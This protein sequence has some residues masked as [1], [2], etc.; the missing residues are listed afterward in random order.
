MVA[1][2]LA[3]LRH[4][5]FRF[6]W[7]GQTVSAIGDQLNVVAIAAL[8][9]SEG[10]GAGA[11]GIVLAARIAGMVVF[12]PLAGVV[13]DRLPRRSVMAGADVVRGLSVLAI[14]FVALG[15]GA[16][17]LPIAVLAFLVGSGEAFFRPAYMSL[18]PRVLP[19]EEL[20]QGNAV[21]SM[22]VESSL[23]IGPGIAG[24]VL[25]VADPV[26]VLFADFASYA[27]ALA[28]LL[29]VRETVPDRSEEKPA[30][31]LSEAREGFRAVIERP[32]IGLVILMATF[33]LLVAIGPWEVLTPVTADEEYGGTET[34]GFL[35]A[36]FGLG[37]VIGG[38]IGTR[39]R[40]R[41]PGAFAVACLF[42]FCLTMI[43]LAL[44]AP[45]W[46]LV[47]GLIV[48]G[49]GESLFTV[50]WTTSIQRDVPDRLLG[51]VFALDW[52]GSIALFPVGLA[53]AG[54][55][56]EQF[57]RAEVLIVGATL[58]S[59]SLV[60]LFFVASV[61]RFSSAAG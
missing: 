18:L 3:P 12:L 51:R 16:P 31:V 54:T 20:Q 23:M 46:L 19:E 21:T 56:A 58:A 50:M 48:S 7:L 10:A 47:V 17:T 43:A 61:R 4:R 27:V 14:A 22:A 28:C 1:P 34:Y 15:E 39:I 26:A 30:G 49:A 6:L 55:A 35:L 38:M 8:M 37:A 40:P 2:M 42:P 44:V 52:F 24:L 59:L 32:W 57:G 41:L 53:L 5:S 25:T 11:L 9:I 33:H 29:P 13:A 60:P 45:V 36:A